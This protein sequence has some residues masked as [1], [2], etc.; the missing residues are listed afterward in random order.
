MLAD[1]A[2]RVTEKLRRTSDGPNCDVAFGPAYTYRIRAI[3]IRNRLTAPRS[4]W[5]NGHVEWLIES[6]RRECLDH[7]IVFGEAHL[8]RIFKRY[9]SH[10]N[11]IRTHLSLAK[12][13]PV[14]RRPQPVGNIAAIPVLGGL[15]DQYVRV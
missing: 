1:R 6:I 7:V 13:L 11:E 15:H 12:D 9:A 8:R 4:P 5:K 10:H 3:G 14:C 2:D